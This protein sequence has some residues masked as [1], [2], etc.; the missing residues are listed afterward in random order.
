MESPLTHMHTR[1][2][3]EQPLACIRTHTCTDMYTHSEDTYQPSKAKPAHSPIRHR[4][5]RQEVSS[6][7]PEY[8]KCFLQTHQEGKMVTVTASFPSDSRSRNLT[9]PTL[10]APSPF[11]RLTRSVVNRTE[12]NSAVAFQTTH[13][14]CLL[15]CG[16]PLPTSLPPFPAK[17]SQ[18]FWLLCTPPTPSTMTLIAV[19]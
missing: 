4:A 8:L 3:L 13:L 18:V 6:R 15:P 7:S 5:S 14:V 16:V 9:L 11:L 10:P 17:C 2:Q 19:G 1:I 12:N